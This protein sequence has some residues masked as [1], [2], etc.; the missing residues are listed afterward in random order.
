MRH[1]TSLDESNTAA[2]GKGHWQRDMRAWRFQ[3]AHKKTKSHHARACLRNTALRVW[4][5]EQHTRAGVCAL[6]P[7]STNLQHRLGPPGQPHHPQHTEHAQQGG[8]GGQGGGEAHVRAQHQTEVEHVPPLLEVSPDTKGDQLQC[9]LCK[10]R[11]T[12]SKRREST[13]S[14][15]E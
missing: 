3:G 13:K 6:A 12:G 8:D 5:R 2:A 7:E 4:A 15:S 14:R 10:G 9:G 1:H 11:I